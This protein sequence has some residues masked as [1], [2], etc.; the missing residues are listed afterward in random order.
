[1]RKFLLLALLALVS[2]KAPKNMAYFADAERFK[3]QPILQTYENKIQKDDLLSITVTSKS[4]EL[5]IPFNTPPSY[6]VTSPAMPRQTDAAPVGYLVNSE[7]D[8]VFPILGKIHV[9]GLTNIELA[10]LIQ[11]LIIDGGYINDPIVTVKLLNYKI[12]I[13]GEVKLP[14]V[15]KIET[16]RVTIMEALS[17]AGDLTIFGKRN[18]ISII[19]EVNGVREI[20]SIDVSNKTIFDS[21]YYYLQPNDVIYVE[22]NQ[23]QK[24][25]SVNS[26]YVLPTVVSALSMLASVLNII[27]R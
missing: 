11:S 6:N 23:K 18:N 27:L 26:P 7:G 17:M 21:P 20:A 5:T 8:I 10:N 19:R 1:M 16:E 24:R 25:Q 2:C 9:A 22:P 4:P 3:E 13:M 14:G 15:K 12:Y